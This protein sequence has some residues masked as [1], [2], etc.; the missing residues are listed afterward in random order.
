MVDG[1]ILKRRGKLVH[2]D[3]QAIAREAGAANAAPRSGQGGGS[4]RWGRAP[5]RRNPTYPY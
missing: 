2:L 5:R 1:R 3:P 4:G